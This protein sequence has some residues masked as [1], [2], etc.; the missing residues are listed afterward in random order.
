[1]VTNELEIIKTRFNGAWRQEA[2][3]KP[4]I[5]INLINFHMQFGVVNAL[6]TSDIY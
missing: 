4:K 5:F 6:F 1:M 2:K 3:V